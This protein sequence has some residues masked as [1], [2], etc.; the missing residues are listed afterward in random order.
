MGILR[1]YGNPFPNHHHHHNVAEV[2]YEL[3]HSTIYNA[4]QQHCIKQSIIGYSSI[5]GRDGN[6]RDD[7]W[8]SIKHFVGARVR[9]KRKS[10]IERERK[11]ELW[12]CVF[13]M[14]LMSF[15]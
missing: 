11:R 13:V 10:E 2:H 4:Y 6:R 3:F 9:E 7:H 5:T 15:Q 1:L 14:C 8:H 12:R